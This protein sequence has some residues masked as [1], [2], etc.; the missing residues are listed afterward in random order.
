MNFETTITEA[1]FKR[2]LL[3]AGEEQLVRQ[4][5]REPDLDVDGLKGS[6]LARLMLLFMRDK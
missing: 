5:Q 6:L 4:M 1:D 2:P 3:D